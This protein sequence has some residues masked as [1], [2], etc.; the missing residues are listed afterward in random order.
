MLVLLAAVAL[1]VP[2]ANAVGSEQ[3]SKAE[4]E[5]ISE[6]PVLRYYLAHPDAAPSRFDWTSQVQQKS[7]RG[8]R[9]N[10]CTSNANKDVFNCDV[11]G[12]PQNEESVGSCATNDNLVLEGTNDYRGL[13][14]P[15]GNFTG[16]HWS[17][18]GG[19]SIRNEGLLPPVGFRT[20]PGAH[21]VPSGGD[22]VDFIPG[23]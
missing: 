5:Q 15:E 19:H 9:V 2:A 16:W 8:R 13:I 21:E 22:P 12:L 4:L 7:A 20:I 3:V 10:S 18:D 6:A 14:D 23:G 11:F 17:T 1:V